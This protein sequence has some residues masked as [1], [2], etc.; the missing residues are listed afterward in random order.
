MTV[1][2]ITTRKHQAYMSGKEGPFRCDNCEYYVSSSCNNKTVISWAKQG[3]YGLSLV[4][5]LAKVDPEGCS[6][7]FKKK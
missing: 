7:E 2:K 1:A 4:G 3:L 5:E 6:D